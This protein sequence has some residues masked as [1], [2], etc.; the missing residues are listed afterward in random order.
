MEQLIEHIQ[1]TTLLSI[2]NKELFFDRFIMKEFS[3]REQLL[4]SGNHSFDLYFVEKGCLR[5][6]VTD[7]NGVEHNISFS[8]ENWWAGDLQSFL[9]KES[10]VYSIQAL[11]NTTV[12]AINKTNWDYLVEKVPAFLGYT[13]VL[14]RNHIFSQQNRISQNLSFTAMERY[15][16]FQQNYPDQF[17][18]ISQKH[19]ASYLGI[20]PEFLS[21]L[22]KKKMRK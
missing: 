5:T 17:Q 2:E 15:D 21:M 19:L 14:F 11:E 13:R 16:Y 4:F 3:K 9:N 8:I 1:N 18:R 7:Y 12:L 20:T 6:F 10:A 22:R